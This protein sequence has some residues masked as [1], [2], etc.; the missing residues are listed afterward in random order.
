M[1]PSGLFGCLLGSRRLGLLPGKPS[2]TKVPHRTDDAIETM[3]I[4][5][6]YLKRVGLQ[7][8][9]LLIERRVETVE[10]PRA[11]KCVEIRLDLRHSLI[12]RSQGTDHCFERHLPP[13]AGPLNAK[14][15][16]F[17]VQLKALGHL[18]DLREDSRLIARVGSFG[19]NVP[20]KGTERTLRYS[21]MPLRLIL[22][23]FVFH[24]L[25]LAS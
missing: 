12:S 1:R 2:L 18:V 4:V 17:S 6:R 21:Q 25:V 8:D 13:V 3:P 16:P 14:T 19:S 22:S 9:S 23:E 24:W 5:T 20:G 7:S 10:G 11:L 15:G